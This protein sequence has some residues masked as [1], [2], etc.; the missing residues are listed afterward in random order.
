MTGFTYES[1]N[2]K[3]PLETYEWDNVWLSHADEPERKR[4]LY[5]GDSIS[6]GT[7]NI[8]TEKSGEEWLFDGFGTS[9]GID[10]P[11]FCASVKLFAEQ[12][13]RRN[14]VIFNNGLHG[15]HLSD[16]SEYGAFYEKMIQFLLKEFDQTPLYLVLSTHV[17]DD[18]RDA[19]VVKR[20]EAV[21]TIAAAYNLPV[22]DLYAVSKNASHL[23]SPDG[24][25]FTQEGYELLAEEILRNLQ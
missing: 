25:H 1:D 19:R 7:R 22:I 6:C 8:A 18:V 17:A 24:V 21:K 16:D 14:A 23:L 9:K 20:N 4:I 10:N 15:W 13:G 3:T 12:E 11:F 5:I 2:R